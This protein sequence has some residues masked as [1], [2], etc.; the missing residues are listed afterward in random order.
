MYTAAHACPPPPALTIRSPKAPF[1]TVGT[2]T[3]LPPTSRTLL[4][5]SPQSQT[6]KRKMSPTL[7]NNKDLQ[8]LQASVDENTDSDF[9]FLHHGTKVRYI[10]IAPGLFSTD[11]M[12]FAPELIPL[13]PPFP[14]G[15]WNSGWIAQDAQT[16]DPCFTRVEKSPVPGVRTAWHPVTLDH[17]DLT[18]GRKLRSGVYEAT[19]PS[20]SPSPVVAK[21]ACFEWEVGYMESECTAYQWIE[22]HDIGPRF[23][24]N[25]A[26]EG[27]IIGFLLK[28]I[29]NA[30][31]ASPA[32]VGVCREKLAA[33][34]RLRI[35]HGDIN[36]H[37]FLVADDGRVTLID[38]DTARRTEDP[39]RFEEEMRGLERELADTSGRGGCVVMSG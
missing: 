13:L 35:V 28:N 34:H 36:R 3:S 7:N 16:G 39:G 30:R 27:R 20:L 10:T 29:A 37:N 2:I 25:I 9:R 32:D 23:L 33:L 26:E 1:I 22:N 14:S 6:K 18:F 11:T 21:F 8:L 19:A 12:C 24:A 15:D 17:L 31:H 38:F 5:S 4:V